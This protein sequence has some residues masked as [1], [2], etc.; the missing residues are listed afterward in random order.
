MAKNNKLKEIRL[1]QKKT[2]REVA[3]A[4]GTS[5]QNISN[6]ERGKS[7]P[8]LAT[9]KKLAEYFNV[10]VSE[11]NGSNDISTAIH[12]TLA[13]F[14][15]FYESNI[16]KQLNRLQNSKYKSFEFPAVANALDLILTTDEK[17]FDKNDINVNLV[18]TLISLNSLIQ[19]RDNEYDVTN[20]AFGEKED[21]YKEALDLFSELLEE[22][23]AQNKKAS[24]D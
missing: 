17:Y 11:L 6:W 3:D 9:W 20:P 23:K 5:N 22:I 14:D 4:L 2:L 13:N 15:E 8:K 24:D 18:V 10:S 12:S 7:E 21:R 1:K 19:N 16:E